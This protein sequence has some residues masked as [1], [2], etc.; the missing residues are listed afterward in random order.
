MNEKVGRWMRLENAIGRPVAGARGGA[1]KYAHRRFSRRHRSTSAWVVAY[2]GTP[3]RGDEI[4]VATKSGFTC[5]RWVQSVVVPAS[6]RQ[7]GTSVVAVSK[8][9]VPAEEVPDRQYTPSPK[10]PPALTQRNP[11][12]CEECGGPCRPGAGLCDSCRA[13]M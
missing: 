3:K 11:R 1:S 5:R 9:P 12:I 4:R 2:H 10:P 7:D 8:V 13:S 6:E